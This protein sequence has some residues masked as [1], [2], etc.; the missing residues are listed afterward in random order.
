MVTTNYAIRPTHLGPRTRRVV[1][2]VARFVNPAVVLIAGR[3]WMPVIGILHH[4]GRRTGREYATPLGMRRQ[5]DSF[6]M[7]RTFGE[8]AAWYRNVLAAGG[9]RVTYLG[10]DYT[11]A[12]PEVIDYATAAS[13]FPR[14]ERLQFRLIG[15]NEY[16]RLRIAHPSRSA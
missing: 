7:P 3:S 16:L 12:E 14:Y 13:A 10:K 8:D 1:R 2:S 11:L 6:V 9:C 5:G 15:I 4:V